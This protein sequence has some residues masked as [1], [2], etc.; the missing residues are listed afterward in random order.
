[1]RDADPSCDYVMWECEPVGSRV[2]V[3]TFQPK[4]RYSGAKNDPH[5]K[6]AGKPLRREFHIKRGLSHESFSG[7]AV[8]FQEE[9]FPQ[10]DED[11]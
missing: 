1:M 11:L 2:S 8:F 10:R 9:R 3:T 6:T 7:P 4:Q 5:S